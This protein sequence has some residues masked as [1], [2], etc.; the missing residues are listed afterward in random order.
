MVDGVFSGKT[1]EQVY[2]FNPLPGIGV[3][4]L[5]HHFEYDGKS[6]SI[7]DDAHGKDVYVGIAELPVRPVQ[8]KA[9]RALYRNQLY[10]EFRYEIGTNL[11][12]GNEPLDS[13]PGRF[14]CRIAIKGGGQFGIRKPL[15]LA[16]G[17]YHHAESLDSCQIHTFTK[18]FVQYRI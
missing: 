18:M 17:A 15:H 9:V 10:Y 4:P 2:K 16:E 13:S 1:N 8:R 3:T 7:V 12:L 5:V 11:A 14:R 6:H